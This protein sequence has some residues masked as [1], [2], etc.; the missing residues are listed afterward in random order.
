[1]NDFGFGNNIAGTFLLNE[2]EDGGCRIV[3]IT[4][5]GN[6]FGIHSFERDNKFSNQQGVCTETEKREVTVNTLSFSLLKDG[7]ASFR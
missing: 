3:T 1:M 7:A 5:D 4:A 6:W 2:D